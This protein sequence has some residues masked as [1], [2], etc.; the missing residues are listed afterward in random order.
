MRTVWPAAG[1]VDQLLSGNISDEVAIGFIRSIKQVKLIVPPSSMTSDRP[2]NPSLLKLIAQALIA[3]REMEKGGSF[4]E[5]ATRL[6]MAANIS[7]T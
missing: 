4:Q 5:V 6:G 7:P 1:L 3:R 2:R